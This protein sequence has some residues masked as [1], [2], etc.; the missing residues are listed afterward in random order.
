MNAATPGKVAAGRASYNARGI[1]ESKKEMLA[2]AEL[3]AET[4]SADKALEEKHDTPP[5]AKPGTV[6]AGRATYQNKN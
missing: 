6:A 3:E 5:P 1:P 4:Q 2:N